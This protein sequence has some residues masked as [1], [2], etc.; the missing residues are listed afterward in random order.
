MLGIAT[1]AHIHVE[2]LVGDADRKTTIQGV[3]PLS[4]LCVV[5]LVQRAVNGRVVEGAG[6][7]Q[8]VLRDLRG[9][10]VLIIDQVG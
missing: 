8:P 3:A 7:V 2:G 5:V 4:R 1:V 10:G 9:C 6:H